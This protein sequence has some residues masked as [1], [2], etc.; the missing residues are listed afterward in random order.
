MGINEKVLEIRGHSALLIGI[1]E[2]RPGKH[3]QLT[4]ALSIVTLIPH[5]VN[6]PWKYPALRTKKQSVKI[7][8]MN[9]S[10]PYRT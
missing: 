7:N 4:S 6:V 5:C 2:D 3:L 9:S 10:R 1:K 8:P